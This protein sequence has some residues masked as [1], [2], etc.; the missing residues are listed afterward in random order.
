MPISTD[1]EIR[2]AYSY[3]EGVFLYT[4]QKVLKSSLSKANNKIILSMQRSSHRSTQKT[5]RTNIVTPKLL[6]FSEKKK[7]RVEDS[8]MVRRTSGDF[9][10]CFLLNQG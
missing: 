5:E 10:F 1:L 4:I 7:E 9:W 2:E 3:I 8:F 6:N